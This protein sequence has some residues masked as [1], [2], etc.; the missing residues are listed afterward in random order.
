MSF[1]KQLNSYIGLI[2]FLL[3]IG[4]VVAFFYLAYQMTIGERQ[5]E[6]AIPIF[7]LG[8]GAVSLFLGYKLLSH[9]R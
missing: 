5:P 6:L 1:K 2:I 3:G 8:F 4:G 9:N 7:T